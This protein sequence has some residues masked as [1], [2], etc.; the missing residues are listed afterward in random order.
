MG[1]GHEQT[2]LKRRQANGQQYTKR[3][4]AS[5]IT[6]EMQIRMIVRYHLTPIRMAIIKKP[7]KIGSVGNNVKKREPLCTVGGNVN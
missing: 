3:C 2:F 1:K 7:P 5:L 6:R 4:S